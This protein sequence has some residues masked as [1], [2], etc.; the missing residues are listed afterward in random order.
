M[1]SLPD[2]R[3]SIAFVSP[4]MDAVG[5]RIVISQDDWEM[6]GEHRELDASD[7]TSAGL[8]RLAAEHV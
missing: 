3:L 2:G 6:H 8:R 1:R 7:A 4:I 5:E